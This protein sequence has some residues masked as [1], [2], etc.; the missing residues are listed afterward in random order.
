M[1]TEMTPADFALIATL[2]DAAADTYSAHVFNDLGLPN[3]D[4]NWALV[5]AV[6][7]ELEPR[8][9]PPRDQ[10]IVTYDWLT[11]RYFA[12]KAKRCANE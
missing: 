5:Q 10:P 9:R 12:T 1:K 3:T 4:A 8:P 2:L 7:V 11:M 6:E